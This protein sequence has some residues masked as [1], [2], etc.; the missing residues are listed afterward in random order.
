LLAV[1]NVSLNKA[2]FVKFRARSVDFLEVNNPRALLEVNLRKFTCLTVGDTIRITHL[3]KYFELD[4]REVLPDSA[5]SIIETDCNVDFEEP[6]GYKDSKYAKYE[7]SSETSSPVVI[8]PR[9]LQKARVDSSDEA[10]A[11]GTS[12]KAFG[13][14]AKRIDGKLTPSA[15]QEK[16]SAPAIREEN[17]GHD[18]KAEVKSNPQVSVPATPAYQSTIGDK[19]SKKKIGV[20]AFAG[21]ARKLNN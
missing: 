4:V 6:L 21:A 11:M 15:A 13:G 16:L 7:R 9:I 10:L 5:A 19:Y 20:A 17:K 3:G 12:F 1:K 2:N 8:I 14:T 18:F